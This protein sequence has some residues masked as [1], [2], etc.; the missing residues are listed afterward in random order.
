VTDPF[1]GLSTL[2]VTYATIEVEEDQRNGAECDFLD[3]A[4]EY[5]NLVCMG[6]FHL[7]IVFCEDLYLPY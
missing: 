3:I 2:A 5:I 1:V 4:Q 6:S 7:P